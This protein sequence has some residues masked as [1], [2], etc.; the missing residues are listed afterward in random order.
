MRLRHLL[1]VLDRQP[2]KRAAVAATL[3]AA[4]AGRDAFDLLIETGMPR[5]A[6]FLG[7]LVHRVFAKVLPEP[8]PADLG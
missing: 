1:A 7:E 2:E 5:E 6:G 3:R 8:P 4:L